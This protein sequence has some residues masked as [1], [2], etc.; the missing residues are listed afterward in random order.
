MLSHGQRFADLRMLD[1]HL[2]RTG[3]K[4]PPEVRFGDTYT[5]IRELHRRRPVT[6]DKFPPSWA[7][8]ELAGW[9]ELETP[10]TVHRALPDA[11]LTWDVMYHTLD[12]YGDSGLTPREQL[13]LRYFTVEGED[14]VAGLAAGGGGAS[15]TNNSSSRKGSV[16]SRHGGTGSPAAAAAATSSRGGAMVAEDDIMDMS[17]D[18]DGEYA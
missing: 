16:A 7:L 5:A 18:G 2:A 13:V 14:R 15:T 9:L 12:R 6:K 11:K 4:V 1:L 10:E 3:N 8:A 17:E